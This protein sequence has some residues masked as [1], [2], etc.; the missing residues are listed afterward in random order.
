MMMAMTFAF[1]KVHCN[2]K[3]CDVKLKVWLGGFTKNQLK[4]WLKKQNW[5]NDIPKP[6]P[7]NVFTITIAFY[8][9]YPLHARIY[10]LKF[11][12]E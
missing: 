5:P 10:G 8:H 7:L 1:T 12:L 11:F 2:N 6:F 3:L 4:E 9:V